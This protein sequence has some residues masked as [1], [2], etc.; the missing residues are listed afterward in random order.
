MKIITLS[1]EEF[2]NFS[3]KNKYN[4]FYQSPAYGDFKKEYEG[5]NVHYLGF[6]AVNGNLVGASLMIYKTLFW[7]YKYAYAPRGILMDYDNISLVTEI[8]KELK[9]LLKKQKFIFVK[10][11]PPIIASERDKDGNIIKFND[12]VNKILK[13]LKDNDYEHIGFNLYNESILP[14]WNVSAKL[15][16]D[17]RILFNNFSNDVKEKISYA[18]NM[19][20]SVTQDV[21]NNLD[22]FFEFIKNDTKVNKKFFIALYNSF[23][24]TGKVKI[25]YSFLDTAKYTNNANKFYASE[26]E[27][28]KALA[29]IIQSGDSINYNIPKAIN[30]KVESDK[31][32][33]KYKKDV[34]NSTNL[35]KKYPDGIKC[36]VAMTIEEASGVNIIYT[37]EDSNYASHNVITLLN[38]EIMKYFGK[39]NYK[40]INLGSITGNFN[41]NSKYYPLLLNKI[42]FNSSILEYIGEFDMIISPKLYKIYKRKYNIKR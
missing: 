27:K 21:T 23:I 9:A 6:E 18:N 14:R 19:A 38:Y 34:V 40:Y 12:S 29:G 16:N 42:G 41:S 28:N 33:S 35:L 39:L 7:G 37:Y 1:R 17:G 22:N 5:F 20:L 2:E 8:T 10:M 24:K 36:G 32:L 26:E 25:F 11:D 30:D 31:M 13:C 15:N 3:N 4:T